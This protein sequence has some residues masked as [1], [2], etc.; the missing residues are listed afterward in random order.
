MPKNAQTTAQ[1]HSVYGMWTELRS[2]H[3]YI[4]ITTLEI[5]KIEKIE[6]IGSWGYFHD[7]KI[8]FFLLAMVV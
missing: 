4:K 2:V 6:I 5:E 1:L 8:V 3:R 7:I